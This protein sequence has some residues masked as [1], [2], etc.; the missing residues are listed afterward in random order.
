MKTRR[1]LAAKEIE[2]AP[3]VG[4]LMSLMSDIP[5]ETPVRIAGVM[6]L[7]SMTTTR[8]TSAMYLQTAK[9]DKES[10]FV[11]VTEDTIEE[12]IS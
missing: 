12:E 9:P 6:G 10:V 3:T 2:Y 11:L 8:L 4:G 1:D 5:P 7:D